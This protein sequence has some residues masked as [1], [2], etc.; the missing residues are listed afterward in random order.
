MYSVL[1]LN[2]ALYL[3]FF[4]RYRKKYSYTLSTVMYGYYTLIA[5]L[6][7][8]TVATGIYENVFQLDFNENFEYT[9]YILCFVSIWILILPLNKITY[10]NLNFDE[11]PYNKLATLAINCWICLTIPFLLLKIYQTFL[12]SSMGY[13]EM[14]NVTVEEGN[15]FKV[16]YGGNFILLKFNNFNTNLMNGFVP[17]VMCYAF[18]GLITKKIITQKA[19]FILLLIFITKIFMALALGSRGNLF[20]TFWSFFFYLII[21][22]Q[23]L[24]PQTKELVKKI[25]SLAIIMGIFYA[26]AISIARVG[27]SIYETPLESIF[28]YFGEPFPNLGNLYWNKVELHPLGLRL[29]PYIFG[30]EYEAESVQDG[31]RYWYDFTGVPVLNF[32][33]IFGDLYIEFGEIIAMLIIAFISVSFMLFLGKKKISFWKIAIIFWY[34]EIV[35]Q[36]IFGF[37]KEG[38]SNLIVFIAIILI[39][40]VV[41]I[42]I[43]I[44]RKNGNTFNC[45]SIS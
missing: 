22:Y 2:L 12:A 14:Y 24:P 43:N 1:L 37:V 17:F 21:F 40:V 20:F 25:G 11:I 29:F 9:P 4:L 13:N 33:T 42:Y 8:F 28:R 35:L 10:K 5:T 18:Y 23:H 44:T 26:L 3:Y 30:I 45:T 36:G 7:I 15:A 41:K 39:S 27:N 34:F 32:K 6:G 38:K 19:V 31:Y 16:L